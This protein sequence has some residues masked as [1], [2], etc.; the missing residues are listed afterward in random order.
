M[1]KV[2]I[3]LWVV[4][5]FAPAVAMAQETIAILPFTFTDDGRPSPQE[6]KQA[7]SFLI[8]YI[9]K[10][11]KHFRVKPLNARDVN[12]ALHKAG[13][14]ADNLD[15][16]TIKELAEVVKADYILI[17]SVD[18]S[19]QGTSSTSGGFESSNSKKN[20]TQT[21]T[22]GVNTSSTTKKYH[23]TAYIS[24]FKSD[25]TSVYDG[26]KG[27]VFIDDTPDSWKNSILWMVRHFPFY[28]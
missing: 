1:K 14:T 22:Y 6:G 27:N 25:G 26:N 13:I 12:V 9:E 15:D 19:L 21:N 8:G 16:Y 20:Y 28:Q 11:Q 7:Q 2:M 5:M 23:A 10:K 3:F 17:G 4:L 24:I 18:K